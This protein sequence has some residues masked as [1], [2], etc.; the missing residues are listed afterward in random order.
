HVDARPDDGT[1]IG[2]RRIT[3]IVYCNSDWQTTNG[4][5]LRLWP[6][7]RLG[8]ATQPLDITPM[9]G[10][11]VLFLSGCVPHQVMPTSRDR[12]AVTMWARILISISVA[13]H[14]T[15]WKAGHMQVSFIDSFLS[16]PFRRVG[17]QSGN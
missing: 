7:G 14:Y 2:E 8:A 16:E 13:Q 6:Q 11:C 12:I 1:L 15:A 9:G 17:S 5:E 10:K 4:G 3:A